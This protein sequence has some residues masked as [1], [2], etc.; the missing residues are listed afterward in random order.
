VVK[1]SLEPID[2][3][4]DFKAAQ[5]LCGGACGFDPPGVGERLDL[6]V[7][8]LRPSTTYYYAVAARNDAG[9]QGPRSETARVRTR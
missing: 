1:Q 3:A 2:D 7:T 9:R 5:T 6:T 4:G 8:D